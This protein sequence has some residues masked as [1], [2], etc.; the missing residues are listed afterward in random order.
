MVRQST[1]GAVGTLFAAFVAG[2][3][4]SWGIS[5]PLRGASRADWPGAGPDRAGGA[6][7]GPG[8]GPGFR[9]VVTRRLALTD[10]QQDSVR[11]I[12]QRHRPRAEAL[13]RQVRPEFDSLR[14]AVDSEIRTQLTPAQWT[15]YAAMRQHQRDR[16]RAARGS[17]DE[18]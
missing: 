7:V 2:G 18:R 10:A 3:L 14:S 15:T 1:G 6:L 9:W 12:F 5:A 4:V 13:W 8:W 11:A 17:P 16:L